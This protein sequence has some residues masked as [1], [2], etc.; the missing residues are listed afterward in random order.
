MPVA[1]VNGHAIHFEDSGGSGPAVLFSHG[2]LMD[3]SMF[4]AQVEALAPEFRCIRWDERGFGATEARGPFT[5]WDSADD[6]IGLLDHLGIERA[7]LVGMSQGG[8]LSLRAAL[9][10]PA[11]VRGLG[12]IDTQAGEEDPE[13]VPQY[14]AM[15]DHWVGSEPLDPVADVVAGLILGDEALSAEWIARWK[16]RDRTTLRL[17]GE[18]L[19]TRD[20]ISARLPEIRCPAIIFHGAEDQAIPLEKAEALQK[21]LAD[22]RDLVVV[23]GAA[24]APNMTHAALV[25]G[26]LLQFLR[27]L[28]SD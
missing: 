20:D 12:L 13:V 19:L 7:V 21:G 15:I 23:P 14:R 27:S 18:C 10:H 6:C 26:P 1:D 3:H 5:Y 25:N 28:P 17:P 11:R 22:C 4:D 2:F 16:A 24:H 9:A 8:F